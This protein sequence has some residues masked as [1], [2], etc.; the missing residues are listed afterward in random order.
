MNYC[1]S[2]KFEEKPDIGYLRKLFKD[3]FYR[4][5]YEY[6]FVYDWLA[7]QKQNPNTKIE[8]GEIEGHGGN[9]ADEKP[10]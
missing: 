7:K 5:G 3:L 6:D 9:E 1:R 8:G 10:M 2:L 4:M